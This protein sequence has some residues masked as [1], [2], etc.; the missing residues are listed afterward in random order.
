MQHNVQIQIQML[1]PN[2]LI[3]PSYN[4][5]LQYT[6]ITD[7]NW[8]FDGKCIS[9]ALSAFASVTRDNEWMN[10]SRSPTQCPMATWTR[11]SIFFNLYPTR[12]YLENR[13]VTGNPTCGMLG[14]TWIYWKKPTSHQTQPS[15]I[16]KPFLNENFCGEYLWRIGFMRTWA[17][18]SDPRGYIY[19]LWGLKF[20]PRPA[21]SGCYSHSLINANHAAWTT[22]PLSIWRHLTRTPGIFKRSQI[23]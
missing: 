23:E 16:K 12:F 11:P 9:L 17:T 2:C 19:L 18:K 5:D 20:P 7:T 8:H 1:T 13:Q 15:Q 10:C 3:A 4:T 6:T 21:T 14:I 22:K